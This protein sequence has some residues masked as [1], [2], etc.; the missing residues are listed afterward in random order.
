MTHQAYGFSSQVC[1]KI[2]SHPGRPVN[3]HPWVQIDWKPR[4]MATVVSRWRTWGTCG[5]SVVFLFMFDM[6]TSRGAWWGSCRPVWDFGYGISYIY[7]YLIQFG[8]TPTPV[9]VTN[10]RFI[11]LGISWSWK[12]VRKL[13]WWLA[14][15]LGRGGFSAYL[16]VEGLYL[17]VF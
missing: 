7:I 11:I 4:Y 1:R 6:G 5:C 8:S 16:H 2:S 17:G 10:Q 13:E 14:S 9:T 15:S 3:Y 12:N